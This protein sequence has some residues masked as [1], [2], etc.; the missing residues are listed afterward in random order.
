MN[1]IQY[2]ILI[3]INMK[4]A[5]NTTNGEIKIKSSILEQAIEN[6]PEAIEIMFKQ[7]IPE[8]EVIHIVQYLGLRG[9]WGIGSHSFACLTNRRVADMSVG[10]FG[11]VVYQDGYLEFINSSVIYQPSKLGL[12]FLVATWIFI[13]LLLSFTAAIVVSSWL[14]GEISFIIS[15]IIF[16]IIL[17][18]IPYVVKFHYGRVK[19]GIIFWVKEGVPIYIFSNRKFIKRANMLCRS[20]TQH[21]ESRINR[22]QEHLR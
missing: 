11:E 9:I 20:V 10:R 1:Q 12:Y 7:F 16:F 2:S 14:S 6:N 19:Y 5:L 4:T 22:I 18:L 8:E 17:L 15:I 21:R 3:A 13:G